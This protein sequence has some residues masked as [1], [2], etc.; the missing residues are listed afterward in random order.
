MLLRRIHDDSLSQ[1]AYL[2]GCPV[3]RE[4]IVF[5]CARDVDRALAA[6][7]QS[8]LRIV[9]AADTHLHADFVSGLRELVERHGV[10]GYLSREGSAPGWVQA[11]PGCTTAV[12][13]GDELC[14]GS[15]RVR[16]LHTPGHT[17]E[18]LSFELVDAEGA[19]RAILTG[20]FLFAGEVGRP[21]LGARS[22]DTAELERNAR[23]LQQALRRLAD[24]PDEVRI[25]PGHTAG[26]LCGRSICALPQ[27]SL[28]IERQINGSLRA[29]GDDGAFMDKVLRGLPDP[30]AYFVR[31]K[32]RNLE[33]ASGELRLPGRLDADLFMHA[34]AEPANVV[35]DCRAWS[36]FCEGFLPGSISAPLD[37]HFANAAGSY[38]EHGDAVL[39]V[40]EEHELEKAVRILFR[41]GIDE[42]GGWTTPAEF[43]AI[44]ED[45][46]DADGI[47]DI[48]ATEAHRRWSSGAAFIDVRLCGEFESGHLPDAIFAPFSQLPNRLAELPKDRELIAYCRSG[49]R[50]ARACAYLKRRGY[51][52]SNLRGGYW[53]WAGR[54]LPV[55][56]GA[57][58]DRAH[59]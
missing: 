8:E 27:S 26:S 16:V 29:A 37:R 2:V 43:D 15:V 4:A 6:A 24:M 36:R 34:A 55:K 56:S 40:C 31:V 22:G 53:P 12:G 45:A 21:D 51:R 30:P 23:E 42:F 28:R 19:V 57:P 11:C 1:A 5:D 52:V 14:V 39:L 9:A 54:G 32:R 17:R 38:L 3:S 35:I 59:C 13:E 46:F 49:S 44:P 25:L 47:E 58:A 10:H 7:K 50:S 18:S 48:G 20:D 41:V 33:G